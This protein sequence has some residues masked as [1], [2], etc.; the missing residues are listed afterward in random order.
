[1][2]KYKFFKY[3]KAFIVVDTKLQQRIRATV[4]KKTKKIKKIQC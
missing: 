2:I 1:M 4:C 3:K